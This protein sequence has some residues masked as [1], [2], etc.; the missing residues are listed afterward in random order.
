MRFFTKMMLVG[1]AL[2]AYRRYRRN[3]VARAD[4]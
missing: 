2:A 4:W 1:S 3:R